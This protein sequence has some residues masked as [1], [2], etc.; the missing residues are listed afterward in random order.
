MPVV[1]SKL[2]HSKRTTII[3]I[4]NQ[5]IKQDFRYR[6]KVTNYNFVN[7]ENSTIEAAEHNKKL[8]N[9][10]LEIRKLNIEDNGVYQCSL[11]SQKPKKITLKVKRMLDKV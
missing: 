5:Q 6:L 10:Q 11:H 2:S 3:S 1:W 8:I 7:N 9:W 4:G